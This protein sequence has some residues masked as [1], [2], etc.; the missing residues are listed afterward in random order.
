VSPTVYALRV[1][2]SDSWCYLGDDGKD[3]GN[4]QGQR[5]SPGAVVAIAVLKKN[6]IVCHHLVGF[7][8]LESSLALGTDYVDVKL[9]VFAGN[10]LDLITVAPPE[11]G[12][13]R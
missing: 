10:F 6:I 1:A 3:N 4:D 7:V 5:P 2:K 8:D 9:L 12:L 11:S 13:C